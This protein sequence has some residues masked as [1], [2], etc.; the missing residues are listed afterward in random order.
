MTEP[1]ATIPMPRHV[2][3]CDPNCTLQTALEEIVKIYHKY[4]RSADGNDFLD[5]KELK[6]FLTR[7]APIFLEACNRNKPGYIDELFRETDKNKDKKLSF[8]EFTKILAKLT[9]DAHRISHGDDRCG[10]DQD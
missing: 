7:E 5:R 6:L 2:S 8:E 9:D 1:A 10:P 4:S 3:G